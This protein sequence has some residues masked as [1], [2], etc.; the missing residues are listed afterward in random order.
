MVRVNGRCKGCVKPSV[1][2]KKRRKGSLRSHKCKRQKV[3]ETFGRSSNTSPSKAR[4]TSKSFFSKDFAVGEPTAENGCS[5][6]PRASDTKVLQE[7]KKAG[8]QSACCTFPFPIKCAKPRDAEPPAICCCPRSG[9][10][11]FI[12]SL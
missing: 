12:T 2:Y 3:L 6:N 5:S 8:L 10:A 7:K 11:G 9:A 1:P 4:Y